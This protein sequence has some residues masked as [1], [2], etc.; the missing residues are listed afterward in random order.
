M[1]SMAVQTSHQCKYKVPKMQIAQWNGHSRDHTFI[2][3]PPS[4]LLVA[5]T[6]TIPF[7]NY[8]LN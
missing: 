4:H 6:M 3:F 2:P 1:I 8:Y 7:Q 5:D